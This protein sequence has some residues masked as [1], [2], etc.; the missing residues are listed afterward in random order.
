MTVL[1]SEPTARTKRAVTTALVVIIGLSWAYLAFL[2]TRMSDMGSPF[3]MPMT[4]AW[5]GQQAVLMWTM[6]SVMMAGMML[7]SA[8]PMISVYSRTIEASAR[9]LHGS[10]G[11]F[12]A[13]YLATWSGFAVLATAAQWML[14]DAALV[15]TMGVSTSRWLGGA[16]LL[17]AGAYQFTAPKQACLR[18]CRSPLGFLMNHWRNGRA[19]ALV[20][21]MHHGVVCVGCCWALMAVLFVLGVMNLWWIALVAAGVLVEKLLPSRLITRILGAGLVVWGAALLIGIGA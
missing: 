15:N 9:G 16:L 1:L 11:I 6:W 4:S 14:H 19:G 7:P 18:Q 21:G 17:V 5:T 2:S 10:T 12:V 8:A 3:A 20:L 13:G